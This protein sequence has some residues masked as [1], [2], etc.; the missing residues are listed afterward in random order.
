MKMI[1]HCDALVDLH[2]SIGLLRF[3]SPARA[4]AELFWRHWSDKERKPILAARLKGFGTISKL[5]ADTRI[6]EQWIAE[7]QQ[8]LA[9]DHAQETVFAE[10]RHDLIRW[11]V[12]VTRPG[13]SDH[14]SRPVG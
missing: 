2:T 4:A 9:A 7:L 11:F 12:F 6:Q 10:A 8:L 5:F 1:R 13:K 14:E 3:G